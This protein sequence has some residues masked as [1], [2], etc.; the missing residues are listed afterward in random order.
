METYTAKSPVNHIETYFPINQDTIDLFEGIVGFM[1]DELNK[2]ET[3]VF[4][5]QDA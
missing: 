3:E 5:K 2:S 4:P 1:K